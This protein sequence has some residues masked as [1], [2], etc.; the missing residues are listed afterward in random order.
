MQQLCAAKNRVQQA[1]SHIAGWG[2]Y[3]NLTFVCFP[4]DVDVLMLDTL[5]TSYGSRENV[6]FKYLLVLLKYQPC[7]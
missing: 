7:A 4:F 3:V 2:V 1:S 5:I 6:C